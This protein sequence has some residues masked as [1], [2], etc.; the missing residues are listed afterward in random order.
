MA[1]SRLQIYNDAL[2]LLGQR[3]IATLDVNEE[4]RRLLDTVWNGAGVGAGGVE[5]CL[6]QGQWKFARRVLPPWLVYALNRNKQSLRNRPD[7]RDRVR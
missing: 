7:I 2:L 5:A 4:G 1:A 6:E 3:G